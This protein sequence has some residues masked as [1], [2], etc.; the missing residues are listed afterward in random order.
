MNKFKQAR[1]GVKKKRGNTNWK[2]NEAFTSRH[3][4]S[5]EFK[6]SAMSYTPIGVEDVS[7]KDLRKEYSRIRGI[8]YKRVKRLES[9]GY[10]TELQASFKYI[11]TL[12]EIGVDYDLLR[13]KFLFLADLYKKPTLNEVQYYEEVIQDVRNDLDIGIDISDDIVG[14]FW[15]MARAILPIALIDSKRMNED[16]REAELN[17]GDDKEEL[18][19]FFRDYISTTGVNYE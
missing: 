4:A 14:R 19:S 3:L 11:P 10:D 16:F 13:D 1:S 7:I 12:T 17:Y 8:V 2:D 5:V 9:K 18:A 15:Q 6:L